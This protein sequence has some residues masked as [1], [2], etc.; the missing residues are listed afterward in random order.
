MFLAACD[1]L[2]LPEHLQMGILSK[3]KNKLQPDDWFLVL[4]AGRGGTSLLAAMLDYHSKL[5]VG[6]ERF[7]FDYLLGE[8]LT[9]T[10]KANLQTRLRHFKVS[11]EKE[12]RHAKT[13]WGNKIT[14]EQVAALGECQNSKWPAYLNH[15]IDEVIGDKKVI[16]IVRDGRACVQSKMKRTEQDYTIALGRW[17]LSI[18]MLDYLKEK[19]VYH[20]QLRY[21]DLVAQPEVELLKV[22]D[23]LGLKFEKRMLKGPGNPIMPDIYKG[24]TL[25]KKKKENWP[26][27]WTADMKP[28]L[29]KLGYLNENW[30]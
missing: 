15:F 12:S 23:F 21:E 24:K 27:E 13:Y 4:G 11:C 26:A 20:Y 25:L 19:G 5:S 22:C 29:K 3:L 16:F 6:M 8:K 2:H 30:S 1:F 28:E 18:A 17:Q 10:D 7:A 9:E 14:T